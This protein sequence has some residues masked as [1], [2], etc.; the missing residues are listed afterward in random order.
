VG[1]SGSWGII[2]PKL[3]S[4]PQIA[5]FAHVKDPVPTWSQQIWLSQTV[6]PTDF[7]DPIYSTL[8]KVVRGRI[9]KW[10]RRLPPF[11]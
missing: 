1:D 2:Q 4:F 9:P 10:H 3:K 11:F 6:H 7:P 5:G 8:V